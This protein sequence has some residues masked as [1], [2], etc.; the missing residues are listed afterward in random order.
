L[1]WSRKNAFVNWRSLLAPMV[2]GLICVSPD[3]ARSFR[4]VQAPNRAVPLLNA[5]APPT[6]LPTQSGSTTKSYVDPCLKGALSLPAGQLVSLTIDH[7]EIP[8]A[9]SITSP[10]EKVVARH[11][12]VS[13]AP[14]PLIFLT[15][16][17]GDYRINLLNLV[18]KLPA[19]GFRCRDL[20]I[21]EVRAD[22]SQLIASAQFYIDGANLAWGET[23]D[24][25]QK[26]ERTLA[27]AVRILNALNQSDRLVGELLARTLAL[28][29]GV[30]NDLSRPEAAREV[31][32]RAAEIAKAG[33]DKVA[34]TWALAE[35]SRCYLAQGEL[36][37][38]FEG[39]ESALTAA[40]ASAETV[41]LVRAV[42]ALADLSYEVNDYGKAREYA[43][44]ELNL[45]E[46]SPSR[47]QHAHA[48]ITLGLVESDV[49][50]SDAANKLL[51]QA[52]SLS[53]EINYQ[54]GA[55]DA[56]TYL[57][58]LRAKEGH[59]DKAIEMY[60]AAEKS[61]E[62]LGDK[63]RQ[64]WIISGMGYVYDQM[65]D[66]TRALQR[67]Q[68]TLKLRL[69]ARNL[70]AEGSIYR[71]LGAEYFTLHDYT[72]AAYYFEKA[73]GLYQAF[74]QWRY[75]AVSLRDL[76]Q[77]FEE[78]GD[79]TKAASYYA[80][81]AEAM[82][83]ADDQR[84]LAYLLIANG[85]L[86]ESQGSLED[87]LGFYERALKLHRSVNDPRGE[88]EALFH[89]GVVSMKQGRSS[90]ALEQME[91][92]VKIDESYRSNIAGANFRASFVA[93]VRR[94]YE[95]FI[96]VLMQA[97]KLQPNFGRSS[98]ALEVNERGRARSFLET[99][100]EAHTHIDEGVSLELVEK[101]RAIEKELDA[102]IKKQVIE[103]NHTEQGAKQASQEIDRL[104][105]EYEL[106]KERI[107]ANSPHYAALTQQ[108][109]LAASDLQKI[110]D[111]NSLMLEY[112]LGDQRSYVWAVSPD[113]I[114]GVELP[115]RKQIETT[116]QRVTQS[117]TER[118]RSVRGETQ[119][120]WRTRLAKADADYIEASAELSKMVLE[121]VASLLGNKD[122]VIVPDGALQLISFEALPVPPVG[123]SA[124]FDQPKKADP[125]S[126]P[127]KRLLIEDH[128]IVYEPSGSV[129]ALQRNELANRSSAPYAVA[130]LANPVFEKDDPRIAAVSARKN[131]TGT[132]ALQRAR[133][134]VPSK[135][136]GLSTDVSR[137]LDDIGISRFPPLLSSQL[138]AESIMK[139]VPKGQGMI[140]VDFKASRATATSSALSQYR[141]IHFATHGVV[142]FEHPDLSGVVLSMVDENGQPQDGYLRLHDIYNLNLPADL[143]VLSA[144]QTG[145]GKQIK[146]EGL[147]AL[148]RGF[149]YAGASRV[150][151]S[152]WKVDDAAT[153]QLMAEFYKQ[154]FS[155]GLKPA[156]A[157]RAAQLNLSHQKRWRSP[158]YWA[159]FVLQGEW[160]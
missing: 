85:R 64:S 90:I 86:K 49:N 37:T 17:A 11:T 33:G 73:I 95:A 129:L 4:P 54:G 24:Q 1:E 60:S 57:G 114:E 151:A 50:N 141:I 65:G 48:L 133:T 138:E 147:I 152:L 8:L 36:S 146:G 9:T 115:G 118:N 156:A 96:D 25:L 46:H 52:L 87:A 39:A 16:S 28:R 5:V 139:V 29:G 98:R 132:L 27:E 71:R 100:A 134:T 82:E 111:A 51:M 148:T 69:L 153:A 42:A 21:R 102:R 123:P 47:R 158:Y 34:E 79:Q 40:K 61:A 7:G 119:E 53:R 101:E 160:K 18:T 107:R 145:V 103:G 78:K 20:T 44:E 19:E 13:G 10:E 117:L 131:A 140:A 121:P 124:L 15:A 84:S 127:A 94:H 136:G 2:I 142:D 66:S 109:T 83:K 130:V 126:T 105:D 112:S 67:Y 106:I 154:M 43:R 14:I 68:E 99:L 97:E 137:A 125:G 58:H 55:V 56:L 22:D 89:L 93:D 63:L 120:Q 157:L 81:A 104:G 144:C 128:Q 74:K 113:A 26:S 135:F 41:A 122:L 30:L 159:G 155:D 45:V 110:L 6:A 62:P 3:V 108:V 150:V 143:V 75:L 38:A 88:S 12:S 77:V 70:P 149:M 116:A 59:L 31:L 80:R 91:A 76:G 72:Q 35:M 32:Q 23:A 92:A